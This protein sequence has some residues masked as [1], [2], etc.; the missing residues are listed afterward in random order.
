[1]IDT[2]LPDAVDG[3]P[4]R[5]VARDPS[6]RHPS[7]ELRGIELGSLSRRLRAGS[8]GVSLRCVAAAAVLTHKL[9]TATGGGEVRAED[10]EAT[11][12]DRGRRVDRHIVHPV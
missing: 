8:G 3:P 5:V 9:W 12:G 4:Q 10:P 1:M 2:E 6:T 7:R 11:I